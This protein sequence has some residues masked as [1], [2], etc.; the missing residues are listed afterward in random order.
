MS[1]ETAQPNPVSSD[2]VPSDPVPPEAVPDE[3]EPDGPLSPEVMLAALETV[4]AERDQ[5]LNDLQRVSAELSNFRKQT[6]RRHA[7]FVAQAGSRVVEALLPVLDACD[8]AAQQGAEGVE[9]IGTQLRVELERSGLQVIGALGEPFDP[10]QHEA[11]LSEAGDEDQVGPV[12]D[13]IL[14]TGYAWKGRVMR[15]AM[16]KVKG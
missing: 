6:E 1:D 10:N 9:Q 14:R 5:H 11:V 12:V 7:E 3:P 16:V 15:A 8:A 13:Q 2:P 4:M